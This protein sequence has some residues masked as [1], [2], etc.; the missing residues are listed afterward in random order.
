MQ[1][2]SATELGSLVTAYPA[3]SRVL[4]RHGLDF[5]CGGSQ[6]LAD[7]CAGAGLS[8]DQILAEIKEVKE[9]NTETRWD[10]VAPSELI[11]HILEVYHATLP[12]ELAQLQAMADKVLSVHGDKDPDRL[13]E[14][15]STVQSLVRDL[16]P[17]MHKEEEILFP[18]IVSDR[19]PR[20][21]GPIAV[22]LED[23]ETAGAALERIKELTDNFMV[24]A[25]ACDTWRNLYARLESFDAELREHI[26]LENNILF[27]RALA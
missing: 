12:E 9:K 3:S 25:E 6:T 19:E 27:P 13:G 1:V 11:S 23:H 18:W 22:M 5:C 15:A 2:D 8:V 10:H 20:P 24:P 26:H 4:V 16:M 17:H 14:L 7:A 21:E